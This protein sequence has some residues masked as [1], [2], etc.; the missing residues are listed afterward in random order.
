VKHPTAAETW[1]ESWKTSYAYDRLEVF[2]ERGNAGYAAAYQI[3]QGA[4]LRSV[5]GVASP[6]ARILD[7]AAAQGNFT[8]RLAELGY[9]VTWNDLRAELAGY[10]E[11]KRER[12]VV[13]Y[14]PG[15]IFELSFEKAFDV[16]LANEVIEHVAH[17]DDFLRRAAGWV[18]PGGHLVLSTPNG[19]YLLNRLPRFSECS[20]AEME[21]RQFQPDA[22]GHLFLLYP[23]EIRRFATDAGLVLVSM[24][25]A[26]NPMTAGHAGSRHIHGLLS[27]IARGLERLAPRLPRPLRER[28]HAATVAVFQKPATGRA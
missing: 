3:R 5:A 20:A 11:Q 27:P 7:V 22:D 25:F 19:R 23:D 18:R 16:V 28:L 14:A 2:G 15:N 6:G 4:I 13:E 17:P 10:V 24:A 1:P 12:G 9:Q 26:V 21:Q 8:L